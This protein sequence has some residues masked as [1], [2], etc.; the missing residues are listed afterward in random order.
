VP[1]NQETNI[2]KVKRHEAC[3]SLKSH[4]PWKAQILMKLKK[5]GTLWSLESWLESSKL[6][7][8]RQSPQGGEKLKDQNFRIRKTSGLKVMV[9]LKWIVLQHTAM[10]EHPQRLQPL[11]SL[12]FWHQIQATQP[13]NFSDLWATMCS[14]I[15]WFTLDESPW[16]GGIPKMR[17]WTRLW[18][19]L[20]PLILRMLPS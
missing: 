2:M 19:R 1:K 5:L 3:I 13:L 17:V 14:D 4:K 20:R 6:K 12:G 18:R 10:S 11:S 16:V 7:R 8:A 9:W 15:G